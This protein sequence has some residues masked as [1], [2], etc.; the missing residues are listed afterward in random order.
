MRGGELSDICHHRPNGRVK[1]SAPK[2]VKEVIDM[3]KLPKLQIGQNISHCCSMLR[4]RSRKI[5]TKYTAHM[6][7]GVS[8]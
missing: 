8:N 4:Q 1:D 6:G 3:V 5:T 2:V 7:A